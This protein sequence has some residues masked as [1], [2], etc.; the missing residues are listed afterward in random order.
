MIRYNTYKLCRNPVW[1]R[2]QCIRVSC[3][4]CLVCRKRLRV[5]WAIRMQHQQMYTPGTLFLTMTYDRHHLP[6]HASLSTTDIKQFVWRLR[7][8]LARH[9]GNKRIKYYIAGEYGPKTH[10]PHYHAIIMGL[11]ISYKDMLYDCW[12]K[13][14]PEQFVVEQTLTLESKLYTSGYSVKKLGA[15]YGAAFKSQYPNKIPEFQRQSIHIGRQYVIDNKDNISKDWTIPWMGRRRSVPRYYRKVI[16]SLDGKHYATITDNIKMAPLRQRMLDQEM[17]I[18][19]SIIHQYGDDV[20]YRNKR[21]DMIQHNPLAPAK[22]D[23]G[24]VVCKP[25]V[26]V[27]LREYQDACHQAELE[28]IKDW[29]CKIELASNRSDS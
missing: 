16:N 2:K 18:L 6:A 26:F 3:G 15:K 11:D 21:G 7:K 10:R 22:H 14:V 28:K 13:C 29:R 25:I 12:R 4:H 17:A 19:H 20:V 9:H 1:L 27:K 23:Y 5:N 8:R 24:G